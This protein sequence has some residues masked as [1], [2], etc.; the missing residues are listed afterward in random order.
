LSHEAIVGAAA[1]VDFLASLAGGNA[2]GGRRAALE[3][4]YAELHARGSRLFARLWDGLGGIAGVTRY[5]LPA[6]APRTPTVSFVVAGRGAHDVAVDLARRAVF[7]SSG[8]F[9]AWTVVQRLGHAED[10]LVRAGCA[11]Y[12]TEE[13]IERLL[14]GVAAAA[15][16]R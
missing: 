5:G 8:D 10:G 16:R 11:I 15:S 2:A 6:E 9:Y 7:A 3:A 13:E 14:E 1:A 4:V 12:T